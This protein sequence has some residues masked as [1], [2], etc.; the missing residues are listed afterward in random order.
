MAGFEW[1]QFY[2]LMKTKLEST[3]ATTVGRYTIP[4]DPQ[5]P[6][7]DI[8]LADVPGGNYDLR[9]N[10]H[11]ERPLIVIEVYCD[12]YDDA[13]CYDVSHA[14]KDI[15]LAYGFQCIMGPRKIDNSDPSVARWSARY[16]RTFAKG[17]TLRSV[18]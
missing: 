12:N 15:M 17:D 11:S 3:G 14:A 5:Y 13:Q 1:N 2:T 10:E 4:K 18:H 16:Q 6:Y 9:N 7:T 8:S